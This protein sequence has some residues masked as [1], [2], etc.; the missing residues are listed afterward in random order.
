MKV[1]PIKKAMADLC[2]TLFV[3]K[4]SVHILG[5]FPAAC[6]FFDATLFCKQIHSFIY[7]VK[8]TRAQKVIFFLFSLQN[9]VADGLVQNV[10]A[11]QRFK[12]FL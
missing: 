8:K 7:I 2:P 9:L 10:A 4:K 3:L 11:R 5:F 12:T 6:K 1:T